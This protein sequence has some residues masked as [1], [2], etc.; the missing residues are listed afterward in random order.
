MITPPIITC[1]PHHPATKKDQPPTKNRYK[2]LALRMWQTAKTVRFWRNLALALLAGIFVWF[3]ILIVFAQFY[4]LS[5]DH[6]SERIGVTFIP[7]YARYFQLDPKQ[8]LSALQ[9][10]LGIEHFRLVSYWSEIESQKGK[11]DFSELDWQF[12]MIEKAGGTVTLSLGLRQPRWPECHLPAW[13][14]DKSPNQ[15]YPQLS[16][17]IEKVVNRYKDRHPLISYQLENEYF[18]EVFGDCPKPERSQLQKEFDLVRT[19][20]PD[21]PIVMSLANNILGLPLRNPRPDQYGVSQYKVVWNQVTKRDY[22]TYPFPSWYYGGR[23]GMKKLLTG[24]PSI[25]HEL[26]AEPWGPTDIKKLSLA[27]QDKS[28]NPALL[29]QQLATARQ[30]GFRDI[31]LWGGEWWYWQKTNHHN[32]AMW[33]AVRQELPND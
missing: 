16:D 8:T 21:T 24:K 10:D 32:P 1:M 31:Y 4:R 25:L 14:K 5:E 29:K 19:T 15:Y 26:Q 17:Y 33:E 28:M 13:A 11:Y 18:L 23:A 3:I 22:F 6:K 20:D 9:D 2:T 30:A 27:E 7:S 12:D